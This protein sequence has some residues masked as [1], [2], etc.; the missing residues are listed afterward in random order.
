MKETLVK[1][2]GLEHVKRVS[3]QGEI[4]APRESEVVKDKECRLN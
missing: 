1:G 4:K 3:G 2:A